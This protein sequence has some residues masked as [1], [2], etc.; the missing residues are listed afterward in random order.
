MASKGGPSSPAPAQPPAVCC[1]CGDQG[2][3]Q[4]LF[5]CKLCLVRS[6]H[7]YCSNLY[8]KVEFYRLCN[9]CLREEE[10]NS[11]TKEINKGYSGIKNN[12]IPFSSN[13]NN[14]HVDNVNLDVNNNNTSTTTNTSS[15]SSGFKL[16]RVPFTSQLDNPVKKPRMLD[17]S[18]SDVTDH[19]VRSPREIS[20]K[21]GKAR[22]VFKGKVRRY[23]LL[24]EV[25]S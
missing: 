12:A 10:S 24:E 4:E 23:K 17:R 1:M 14:I 20:P 9:W 5:R 8:P 25:S 15:P 6:Q 16:H 22:Q 7:R 18:A 19:R 21:L 13:N 11:S 3:T 2:L